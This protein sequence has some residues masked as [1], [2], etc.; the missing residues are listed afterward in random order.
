MPDSLKNITIANTFA[1][2]TAL[3]G[4]VYYYINFPFYHNCGSE[5]II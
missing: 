5:Y 2:N 4:I 1:V 3:N